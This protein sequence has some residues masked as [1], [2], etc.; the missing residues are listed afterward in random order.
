MTELRGQ[1]G[2]A[3]GETPY[4]GRRVRGGVPHPV[5]PAEPAGPDPA[6][7]SPFPFVAQPQP[8][9]ISSMTSACSS[10]RG[11]GADI[12][13]D[14][15]T[16]KDHDI[17]QATP[18]P[19]TESEPVHQ[20][21]TLLTL[22]FEIR[23]EIY[24]HLLTAPSHPL[25]TSPPS[26]PDVTLPSLPSPARP[27]SS[28][29][30]SSPRP[31]APFF[32]PQAPPHPLYPNILRACRQ[33]HA[34]CTPVLYS[35]NTFLAHTSLLTTFPSYFSPTH[36]RKRF[37]AIRSAPLA[38]LVKRYRVRL[39]LDAEPQFARDAVTAQFSG[40]NEVVVEVWQAVWRGAG[41]DALR[42]FEGVR[43][44]KTAKITGSTSGFEAYAHWLEHAMMADIGD[45]IGPFPWEDAPAQ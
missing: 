22:P 28:S 41:P 44:V 11:S 14:G 31:S 30:S 39:R 8:T 45:Y 25:I 13:H 34:E 26:P 33:L 38:S 9:D 12:P 16:H 29:S 35:S 42:L 43:G 7:P 15:G 37:A 17:L 32:S 10:E 20:P 6:S 3:G 5:E 2:F 36:P 40:K 1:T 21:L 18:S 23:L 24:A 4:S 19:H 27:S